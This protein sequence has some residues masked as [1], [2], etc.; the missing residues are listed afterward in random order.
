MHQMCVL[1]TKMLVI[2]YSFGFGETSCELTKS[3]QSDACSMTS[4]G[5][6]QDII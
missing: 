6:P 2:T 5:D 3:S 4:L 1:D